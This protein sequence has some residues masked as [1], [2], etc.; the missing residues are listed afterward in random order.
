MLKM[1]ICGASG[2]IG[3]NLM[4]YFCNDPKFEVTGVIFKSEVPSHLSGKKF[5]RG[6]LRDI[7]FVNKVCKNKDIILQFA[8]TTSGARDMVL[9][10]FVHVT[11]NAVINSLILRAAF[12][13]KIKKFI[14][15][16]CTVM[17]QTSDKA[18]KEID[19]DANAELQ[20]N[21]FG[22]GIS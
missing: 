20:E 2:F 22:V 8:A 16:S 11:D 13:N 15:P 4:S 6:D 12:E 1:L 5:I 7:N 10:P 21:Y 3:Q 14:F 9:Q 17:Y 18:I 19:F